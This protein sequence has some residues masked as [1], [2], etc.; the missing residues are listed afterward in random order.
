MIKKRLNAQLL[1]ASSTNLKLFEN[2]IFRKQLVNVPEKA[3]NRIS[4]MAIF[5]GMKKTNFKINC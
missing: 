2:F 5:N 3:F 1:V 4:T